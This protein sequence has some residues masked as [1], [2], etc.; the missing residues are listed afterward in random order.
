MFFNL[1]K[2]TDLGKKNSEWKPVKL[3]LRND[4]VSHP[5]CVEESLYLYLCVC[6]CVCVCVFVFEAFFVVLWLMR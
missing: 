1:G 4:L 5:A 6:V 2:S 3:R